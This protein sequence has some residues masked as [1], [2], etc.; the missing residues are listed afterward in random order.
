MFPDDVE[1]YSQ[2]KYQ[3]DRGELTIIIDSMRQDLPVTLKRS[4]SQ[5]NVFRGMHYQGPKNTQKKI[6]EVIDGRII[7]FLIDMRPS[8]KEFGKLYSFPLEPGHTLVIPEHYSHGFF[9]NAD[10]IFQYLT[11]GKYSEKDEIILRLDL[12]HFLLNDIDPNELICSSKD[13]NGVM[14]SSYFKSP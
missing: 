2:S 9:C 10:T 7:D 5:M 4:R 14:Y 1:V 6:I 11:V 3:D 13:L 8:S 12:E